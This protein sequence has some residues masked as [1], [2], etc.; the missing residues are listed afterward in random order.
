MKNFDDPIVEE[1]HQTRARLLEKHG[2]AE[3]YAAHL[4]QLESQLGDRVVSR[5][6]RTPVKTRRKVS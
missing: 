5:K 2:G 6:P 4:R 1:V 3:G